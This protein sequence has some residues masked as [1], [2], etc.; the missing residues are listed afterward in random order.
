MSEIK[1][2]PPAIHISL[3]TNDPDN[4]MDTGKVSAIHVGSALELAWGEIGS[5]P[6]YKIEGNIL[7][8]SRQ[9]FNVAG[10]RDWEGN[11]CWT[12]IWMLPDVA[13][14]FLKYI[15]A[16]DRWHNEGGWADFSD[17]YEAETLTPIWL[18]EN[19]RELESV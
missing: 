15:H 7:K 12:G 1:V 3:C 17:L 2:V 19:F 8:F 4:G 13:A 14:E 18:E 5:E 16:D 9:H 10:V 6:R 11:W